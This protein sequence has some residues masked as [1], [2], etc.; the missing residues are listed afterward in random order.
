[1]S[2]DKIFASMPER[3]QADKAD[4]V[5][6]IVLF[7][8]S[9]DDGGQWSVGVKDGAIDVQ[10]AAAENPTASIKISSEDLQA[11]TS[12]QLNPMMAFMS[13]KIKVDGDLNSVMKF[14]S[15]VGF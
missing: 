11:M 1:M 12:G 14:Q 3:F 8:V 2:L 5:N 6:M 7:D 9:G 15:L 10:K 13:G 4:G